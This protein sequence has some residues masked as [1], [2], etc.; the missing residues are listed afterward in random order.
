MNTR[1]GGAPPATAASVDPMPLKPPLPQFTAPRRANPSCLKFGQLSGG[2]IRRY[3]PPA[4]TRPLNRHGGGY[5]PIHFPALPNSGDYHPN[6]SRDN[7]PFSA[8]AHGP[9]RHFQKY[10]PCPR[11]AAGGWRQGSK[12]KGVSSGGHA[13]ER[14]CCFCVYER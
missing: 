10:L 12:T 13:T 5:A 3:H 9:Q 6:T 14:S 2:R 1:R 7:P 8:G 11:M 4:F